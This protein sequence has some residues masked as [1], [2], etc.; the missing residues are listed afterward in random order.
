MEDGLLRLRTTAPYK[1]V[2]TNQDKT[3]NWLENTP[4]ITAYDLSS[5]TYLT[6]N[7]FNMK[8]D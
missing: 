5:Y 2:I 8:G 1:L 7:V 3:S 6:Y 4:Y